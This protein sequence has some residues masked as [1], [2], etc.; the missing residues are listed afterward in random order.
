MSNAELP[1][2]SDTKTEWSRREFVVQ[3]WFRKYGVA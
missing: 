3:A 1:S 2:L